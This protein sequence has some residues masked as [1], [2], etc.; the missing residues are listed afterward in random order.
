MH[1]YQNSSMASVTECQILEFPRIHDPRGTLTPI[2]NNRQIPFDIK[3]VY[4]LYDIPGG[5]SRAGHSHKQLQQV[6]IAISG[7]F[8][9]HVDD[10]SERLVFHLNR[11]HQGLYVP[12]M[13]W[14]EIDN[15][16]SNAVCVALASMFYDEADYYRKYDDFFRAVKE[17]A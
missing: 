7:S 12:R 6:L 5:A 14:R 17:G 1:N 10:G 4:Y 2:E 16:S 15:F 8:D 9:V 13:I 3:R 11:P